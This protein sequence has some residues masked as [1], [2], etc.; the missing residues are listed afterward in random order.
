MAFDRSRIMIGDRASGL[1]GVLYYNAPKGATAAASDTVSEVRADEY[2]DESFGKEWE[3]M[4]KPPIVVT[5]T[6]HQT[7]SE[8]KKVAIIMLDKQ[9]DGTYDSILLVWMTS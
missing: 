8:A 1:P 2:F 9:S 3:A 6:E 4:S 5:A 7:A